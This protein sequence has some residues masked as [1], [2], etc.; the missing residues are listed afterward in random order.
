MVLKTQLGTT[1]RTWR[2]L[3]LEAMLLDRFQLL[4]PGNCTCSIG[5]KSKLLGS[6]ESLKQS[7][8]FLDDSVNTE[9][10]AQMKKINKIWEQQSEQGED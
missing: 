7:Q 10:L 9:D 8:S 3:M 5:A 6:G 2:G 1:I 4:F